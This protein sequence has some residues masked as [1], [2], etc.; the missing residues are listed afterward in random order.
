MLHQRCCYQR[1]LA[2]AQHVLTKMLAISTPPLHLRHSLTKSSGPFR[3]LET[4]QQAA[5]I[6]HDRPFDAAGVRGHQRHGL[7]LIQPFAVR[8]GQLAE[9]GSGTVEQPF[10]A[11]LPRPIRQL[12]RVRAQ[13]FVVVKVTGHAAPFQP[14]PRLFDGIAIGNAIEGNSHLRILR[15]ADLPLPLNSFRGPPLL[16]R[17]IAA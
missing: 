11:C 7:R 4:H 2:I 6:F 17:S 16:Q 3:L 14:D 12:G 5:G 8:L 13:L 9:G 15:F 10:P 1:S